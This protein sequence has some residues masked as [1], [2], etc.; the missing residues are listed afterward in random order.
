[1]KYRVRHITSYSYHDLVPLCQNQVH[2][3]PRIF[4]R[5]QCELSK[6][7]VQ[8]EPIETH[9]WTDYFGN[10]A[11]YFAVDVP[12]DE[13][14]V[15]AES[16]VKVTPPTLPAPAATP[17][18]E[19]A[20]DA[21][22]KSL[23][24]KAAQFTFE[25]PLVRLIDDAYDYALPSFARGR[26]LLE[27]VL[28]LTGRIFREFKYDPTASCVNTPTE[29]ILRKRRGVCQDFAH[30]EIT[31]LRSLGLA[32]RYVS[33][34]LLTDPPPGQPKLVG[35]DASHAWLSVYCPQQNCWFDLDPTNNQIPQLRHVT[36][37]WGRD[38]SD[39]CPIMGVFLG[40]GDHR[41]YVSVDVAPAAEN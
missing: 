29:E 41:M 7:T 9:A 15:T 3:S 17:P 21:S 38:Y 14:T 2:L 32:A 31:C 24:D 39:V 10:S 18:W 4:D 16:I 37:A 20:R 34:Y 25:S 23:T 13:L 22:A 30:L 36:L 6:V 1:V 27:A 26:P 33:G 19:Q 35:A 12:H 40:G 28:D 8:P 11:L 5:Q